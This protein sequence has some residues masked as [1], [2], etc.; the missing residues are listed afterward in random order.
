MFNKIK[1]YL[2]YKKQMRKAKRIVK[3]MDKER[4]KLRYSEHI[5]RID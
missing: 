2:V 5:P 4:N 3:K 1:K